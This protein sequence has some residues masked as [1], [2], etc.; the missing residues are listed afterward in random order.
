MP[1]VETSYQLP[2]LIS[3]CDEALKHE[4]RVNTHCR[5]ATLSSLQWARAQNIIE[6]DMESVMN[7]L[8]IGLLA[9]LCYP[10]CDFVQLKTAVDFMTWAMFGGL[11]QGTAYD[12]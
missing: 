4:L 5:D 12:E 11:A 8:Q 10:T 2:N 9:S 1:E 3:L 7:K 6:E